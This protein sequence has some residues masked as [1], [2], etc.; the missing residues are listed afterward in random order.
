[1]T[2]AQDFLGLY[3]SSSCLFLRETFAN[4]MLVDREGHGGPRAIRMVELV[5]DF[6]SKWW[7]H[8]GEAGVS[9]SRARR[10]SNGRASREGWRQH[11]V[12]G[13]RRPWRA[14]SDQDG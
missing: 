14:E 2:R 8:E 6:V 4:T 13:S 12:G 11:D 5:L 7:A 1:M 10:R 3:S 9:A